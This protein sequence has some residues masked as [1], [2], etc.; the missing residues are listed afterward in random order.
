MT[1]LA[2]TRCPR[3]VMKRRDAPSL[4]RAQR[5]RVAAAAVAEAGCIAMIR[6][7]RHAYK[8]ACT[9]AAVSP[10][11]SSGLHAQQLRVQIAYV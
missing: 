8:P 3:Y 2:C 10:A 5:A 9:I 4:S 6:P 1:A 11:T 7:A